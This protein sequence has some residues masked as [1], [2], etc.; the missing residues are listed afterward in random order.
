MSHSGHA[1]LLIKPSAVAFLEP[2][3]CASGADRQKALQ[4]L[5]AAELGLRALRDY[6]LVEVDTASETGSGRS[7]TGEG[8]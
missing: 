5:C 3:V 4:N 6:H 2:A 7:G 8:W 1:R